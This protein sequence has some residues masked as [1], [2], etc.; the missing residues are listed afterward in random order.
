M[1]VGTSDN[2][3]GAKSNIKSYY[4][5][6]D[7][8]K[9]VYKTAE[10]YTNKLTKVKSINLKG[11]VVSEQYGDAKSEKSI[12]T[13]NGREK[14]SVKGDKE[15]S[16]QYD[17]W[18]NLT[19]ITYP[20]G[21]SIEKT[22]KPATD[23]IRSETNRA[24]VKTDYTYDKNHFLI[25]RI[26][27][28]GTDVERMTNYDYD[29]FGQVIRVTTSNKD[30]SESFT[31]EYTYDDYGNLIESRG[32]KGIVKYSEF[33]AL[34]NAKKVVVNGTTTLYDYDNA[35]N[36]T[37][38]VSPLGFFKTV[39]FNAMGYPIKE[40][41]RYANTETVKQMTYNKRNVLASTTN[42]FNGVAKIDRSYTQNQVNIEGENGEKVTKKYDK[43]GRLVALIEDGK[44]T[45]E[46]EYASPS[47]KNFSVFKNDKKI[48]NYEYNYWG[49]VTKATVTSVT[50]PSKNYTILKSY[51]KQGNL[52]K[53]T[54]PDGKTTKYVYDAL[55]RNTM[56]KNLNSGYQISYTYNILGQMTALIKTDGK[57]LR[58]LVY[59]ENGRIEKE[60]LG[61]SN[62]FTLYDYDA[63]NRL[64]KQ[65]FPSGVVHQLKYSANSTI[66]EK[67]YYRSDQDFK[68]QKPARQELFSSNEFGL[69]DSVHIKENGQSLVKYGFKY[70]KNKQ[71]EV[72]VTFYN[73]QGAEVFSKTL[74]YTYGGKGKISSYTTPENLT[75]SYGY[76]LDSQLTQ[77]SLPNTKGSIDFT[78]GND[79]IPRQT[80]FPNG[81]KTVNE[82]NDFDEHSGLEVSLNQT[83]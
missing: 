62:K 54:T 59:N 72:T 71:S 61:D 42:E 51:D 60:F 46:L 23:L 6:Y 52:S 53:I 74:S 28:V 58:K 33:N 25:K 31:T 8:K 78:V 64:V 73:A 15:T 69:V 65:T 36:L 17:R 12:W 30:A 45:Y 50:A 27:A 55:N 20:D 14:I 41:V 82:F 7:P 40:T 9:K 4:H 29:K 32:P 18:G 35:G 16:R 11:N 26:E 39:D 75:L 24:N 79:N 49:Q 48:I 5:T 66:S 44:T 81:V 83:P 67:S 80:I 19:K 10:V 22:Y 68:L 76:G 63:Q 34:G 37:K 2:N 38:T 70:T 57:S 43:Y 21:S 56:V 13:N 47:D 1:F 3:D 77:I